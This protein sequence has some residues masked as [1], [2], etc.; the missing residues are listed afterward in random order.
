MTKQLVLTLALKWIGFLALIAVLSHAHLNWW[1]TTAVIIAW[2]A[3]GY[4][5]SAIVAEW[6]LE[7]V[8]STLEA[9]RGPTVSQEAGR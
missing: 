4:P 9:V 5:L 1:E 6:W 8:R 2:C 3:F 7:D